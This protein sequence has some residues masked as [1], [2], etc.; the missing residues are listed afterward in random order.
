MILYL[1]KSKDSTK[2]KKKKL[3]EVIN[4]F[5]KVSGYK[6]DIQKS[7]AFLSTNNKCNGMLW[8]ITEELFISCGEQK[9]FFGGDVISTQS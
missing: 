3:L 6:I 7:A 1:E 5:G 2:K 8:E 9:N 4:E